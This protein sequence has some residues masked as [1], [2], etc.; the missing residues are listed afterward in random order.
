M[1]RV[2]A[3][4]SGARAGLSN[5]AGVSVERPR[6]RCV[7]NKLDADFLS[8]RTLRAFEQLDL[9][10]GARY[11]QA[12]QLLG[13]AGLSRSIAAAELMLVLL[14]A[15]PRLRLAGVALGLALHFALADSMLVSTFSAQM[16]L[17]LLLFLPFPESG[18]AATALRHRVT[19]FTVTSQS[20]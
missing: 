18:A 7:S 8:G 16:A 2:C 10:G 9:L 4:A 17:Y 11:A 3:A 6:T 5:R 19:P 15:V 20:G 14:L 13:Y 1:F 12:L